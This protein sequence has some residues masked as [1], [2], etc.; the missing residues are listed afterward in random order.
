MESNNVLIDIFVPMV[1][2]GLSWVSTRW[3]ERKN[4][5]AKV[6]E[7]I[8]QN[9]SLKK[10]SDRKEIENMVLMA[11]E[12]REM[13]QV[14]KTQADEQQLVIIENAKRIEELTA[15]LAATSRELSV[16]KGQL[17][18]AQNRIKELEERK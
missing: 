8:I 15:K 6:D 16:V 14:W 1:V 10:E 12:W 5:K 11:T 18:R 9:E 17:T 3:Y 7:L 13:A 4:H 2:A